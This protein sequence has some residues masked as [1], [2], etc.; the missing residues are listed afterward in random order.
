MVKR[1]F[2]EEN[3]VLES[4]SRQ[5]KKRQG[6]GKEK[7]E[8]PQIPVTIL[9][10]FLGS[11]KTT[12]LK[13]ILTSREHELK[14]AVIVNDMAELNIDGQTVSKLSNDEYFGEDG[15]LVKTKKEVITLENGCICCTLR[16]DL[17][18]EINRIQELQQFDYVLIESTG[19]AEPQQVAESFCVDPETQA[20]TDNN[21]KML[22]NTARLDACVTVVDAVNF[23]RYLSSL[24]RFQDI[25]Q[26]GLD[27]AAE[28][29]EEGRKS[30]SELMVEQVEFANVILLNK[31]DLVTPNQIDIAKK[32]IG[33]LN[34]NARVVIVSYGKVDLKLVLNTNL[35]S[36]QKAQ[37]SP[38]WLVSLQDGADASK[39]EADEYGVSSF[40]FSERTPF[41]PQRLHAFL[42]QFFYFAEDWQDLV[43]NDT[44]QE[45]QKNVATV[46]ANTSLKNKFGS[47]LRSKG[48]CWIAGRDDHEIGWSQ[49]GP[50][51]QLSPTA[52]W[53]CKTPRN[54][55][56]G[57]ETEQDA[58]TKFETTIAPYT[59]GDRRQEVVFIGTNLQQAP[60]EAELRRCLLTFDEMKNHDVTSLPTGT[61]PDP[62][63][64][65][66]V[67]CDA[68]QSFFL[69]AR[70][71]Q[72]QHIHVFPGFALTITNLA[73]NVIVE[74]L[75]SNSIQAVQIWLDPS[76]KIKRGV[77]LATLRPVTC[78]QHAT[79]MTIL[80]CDDTGGENAVNSR[81]RVEI[82]QKKSAVASATIDNSTSFDLMNALE[83]H[84]MGK[85]EP[86]PYSPA[87]DDSL[88]NEDECDGMEKC[89]SG[90][91]P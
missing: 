82:L 61:Y 48:T 85:V 13:H 41:H 75:N 63:Y 90:D 20:L 56:M 74:G 83:I 87:D 6:R 50:I 52:P 76:D 21:E 35:F 51:I 54:E 22:W 45:Q 18:R 58:A 86:L 10:G 79:S 11:G 34:P 33:S 37:D 59:Y 30:I 69:I 15:G 14:I 26:D 4:R 19:I 39:G 68:A 72:N 7:K 5:K 77:L 81:I 27:E 43:Q 23:P 8:R 9:S 88:D 29:D 32:L 16:G 55:W 89:D 57:V 62:L 28:D 38:G 17:I 73:L 53:Y 47:I 66:L 46:K 3:K 31:V 24:K 60:I 65:I 25:F 84:I 64:P 78:E 80:P 2:I 44:S 36:M 42:G 91:C 70:F 12:L 40:V 71:G 67:P 49:A 1:S